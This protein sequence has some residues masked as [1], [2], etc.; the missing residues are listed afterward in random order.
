MFDVQKP[1]Y[2]PVPHLRQK[3]DG[4]CLPIC[5]YTVLAY[6][7]RRVSLWRLRRVLK[8][9]SMGTPFSNISN[10]TRFGITVET[11]IRGNFETLYNSL[12]ANRPC[13]VSVETADFPHWDFNSLH[14]VVGIDQ[15]YIYINDLEFPNAPISVPY[16]EFDLA[17]LAQDERYAVL[18]L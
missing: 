5:A 4:D 11:D 12:A 3:Q 7:G 14:A 13:I 17:W 10:L 2:L 16:G 9:N 6:L 8:T 18:S 1:I 15:Q